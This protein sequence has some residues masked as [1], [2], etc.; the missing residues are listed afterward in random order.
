MR[1]RFCGGS[2]AN[3]V[4]AAGIAL[5]AIDLPLR[6]RNLRS[7]SLVAINDWHRR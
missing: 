3:I 1:R 7:S 5:M 2:A 6:S 4:Y